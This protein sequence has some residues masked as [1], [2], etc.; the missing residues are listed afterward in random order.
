M[1]TKAKPIM[2]SN[3]KKLLAKIE[4]NAAPAVS[5]ALSVGDLQSHL[6][7]IAGSGQWK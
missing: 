6:E 1:A 4:S 2:K 5:L 3:M 7:L